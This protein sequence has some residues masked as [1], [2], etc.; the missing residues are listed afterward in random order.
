MSDG[1]PHQPLEEPVAIDVAEEDL[2][3]LLLRLR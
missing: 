2:E 3:V 1:E